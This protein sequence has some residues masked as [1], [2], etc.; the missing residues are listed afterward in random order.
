MIEFGPLDL[1]QIAIAWPV[2]WLMAI[3][4]EKA[5]CNAAERSTGML[6][7]PFGGKLAVRTMKSE[8]LFAFQTATALPELSIAIPMVELPKLSI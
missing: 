4:G 8:P 1:C 6:Q 2:V 5:F 7:A 3:W